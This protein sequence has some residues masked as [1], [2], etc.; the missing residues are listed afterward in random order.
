MKRGLFVF[1]VFSIS[2]SLSFAV[3][4]DELLDNLNP[5]S[6]LQQMATSLE[7]PNYDPMEDPRFLLLNGTVASI[8]II[9]DSPEFFE[10]FV[11]LSTGEWT[12]DEEII[13]HRAY[14]LF[15]G[16]EFNTLF[17]PRSGSVQVGSQLITIAR[18]IGTIQDPL[19]GSE[20]LFFEAWYARPAL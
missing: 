15:Y 7:D 4:F 14:F 2:I 16:E 10:A 8:T 11:E 17:N 1:L 5:D 20:V 18:N 3:S 13:L 9:D 12:A 6:S 19:D